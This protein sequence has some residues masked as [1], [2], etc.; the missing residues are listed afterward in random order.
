MKDLVTEANGDESRGRIPRER[1]EQA[2]EEVS[3]IRWVE[4]RVQYDNVK[5]K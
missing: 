4:L 2:V 3:L 1:E 5:A